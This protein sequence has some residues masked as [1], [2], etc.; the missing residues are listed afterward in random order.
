MLMLWLHTAG[1]HLLG[2]CTLVAEVDELD[3]DVTGTLYRAS[4]RHQDL[5]QVK[6]VKCPTPP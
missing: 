1:V 3:A 2:D 6:Q 4:L 5:R